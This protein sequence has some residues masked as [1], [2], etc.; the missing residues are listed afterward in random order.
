M[1]RTEIAKTIYEAKKNNAW[2]NMVSE[3]RGE[4]PKTPKE[5]RTRMHGD[6]DCGLAFAF[7]QAD[8]VIKL[9]DG[10]E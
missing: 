2:G 7:A 4:W 8:A 3:Y 9:L 6:D 1:N 10:V 5:M